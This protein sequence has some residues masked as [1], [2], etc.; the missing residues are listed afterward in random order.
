MSNEIDATQEDLSNETIN[1]VPAANAPLD[2][3]NDP[4]EQVSGET[5]TN[6]VS[7]P[8]ESVSD[9]SAATD[10]VVY[11]VAPADK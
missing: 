6:E 9:S 7:S 10:D 8:Q 4:V 1:D 3:V 11:D 2:D 5:Q